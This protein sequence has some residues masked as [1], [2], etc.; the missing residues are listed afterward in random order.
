VDEY[1]RKRSLK[2]REKMR[3]WRAKNFNDAFHKVDRNQ[4][5]AN[6]VNAALRRKRDETGKFNFE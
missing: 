5:N 3:L 4:K 1:R 2:F 6:K